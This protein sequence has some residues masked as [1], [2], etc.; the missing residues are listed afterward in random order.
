MTF[1]TRYSASASNC[2]MSAG[3]YGISLYNRG[4]EAIESLG[5]KDIRRAKALADT[6]GLIEQDIQTSSG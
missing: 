6:A 4:A 3:D 2:G 5:I 1:P